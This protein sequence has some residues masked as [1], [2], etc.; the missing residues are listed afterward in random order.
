MCAWPPLTFNIYQ[1]DVS[2]SRL[3]FSLWTSRAS[4]FKLSLLS[5]GCVILLSPTCCSIISR[6]RVIPRLSTPEVEV[7]LKTNAGEIGRGG[8]D[9]EMEAGTGHI[10]LGF[11]INGWWAEQTHKQMYEERNKRYNSD[12]PN[13]L[14]MHMRSRSWLLY[15]ASVNSPGRGEPGNKSGKIPTTNS[16]TLGFPSAFPIPISWKAWLPLSW[17]INLPQQTCVQRSYTVRIYKRTW[18]NSL[19]QWLF[20][21]L[22][23]PDFCTPRLVYCCC[24]VYRLFLPKG[25]LF[26]IA[27]LENR[28]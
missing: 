27:D 19:A 2:T 8:P 13:F 18:K 16:R 26:Q 15:R 6:Y 25:K 10:E 7:V 12:M 17:W 24:S 5:R 28:G 1:Y 4:S 20:N 22:L 11:S 3:S 14:T 23:Q 9:T 21:G